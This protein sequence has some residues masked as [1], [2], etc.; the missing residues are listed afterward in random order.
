[1]YG[2]A[3]QL[4]HD[5]CHLEVHGAEAG[6]ALAARDVEPDPLLNRVKQPDE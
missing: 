3:A 1:M 4:V 6:L 2:P 5:V